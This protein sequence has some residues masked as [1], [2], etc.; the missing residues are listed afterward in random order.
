MQDKATNQDLL[1]LLSN[2]IN[3]L[4]RLPVT[5]DD[6]EVVPD[7]VAEVEKLLGSHRDELD[8]LWQTVHQE[9]WWLY[10]AL[11][12][13]RVEQERW[14][15]FFGFEVERLRVGARGIPHDQ[16]E[17]AKVLFKKLKAGLDEYAVLYE[18]SQ[19]SV[20]EKRKLQSEVKGQEDLLID[21]VSQLGG[22]LQAALEREE[23]GDWTDF[24][25]F[26]AG[27]ELV[28]ERGADEANRLVVEEE[29]DEI[30]DV[31]EVE[32][33]EPT[34]K[35]GGALTLEQAAF[36][37]LMMDLAELGMGEE[38]AEGDGEGGGE[39]MKVIDEMLGG[40]VGDEVDEGAEMEVL[41]EGADEIE[42]WADGEIDV[43]AELIAD[44]SEVEADVEDEDAVEVET[45]LGEMAEAELE[46]D[47]SDE[48]WLL[49]ADTIGEE[50]EE[51]VSVVDDEF[52]VGVLAEVEEWI[53]DGGVIDEEEA[54]GE[55]GDV[56][57]GDVVVGATDDAVVDEDELIGEE[58]VLSVD[59]G[60]G[61]IDELDILAGM[62]D[63]WLNADSELADLADSMAGDFDVY[64][65][66]EADLGEVGEEEMGEIPAALEAA[67]DIEPV[68]DSWDVELGGEGETVVSGL[69][70]VSGGEEEAEEA[71][72]EGAEEAEGEDINEAQANWARMM[73]LAGDVAGGYWVTRSLQ[74]QNGAFASLLWP[75][76]LLAAIQ[77]S[78]WLINGAKGSLP[79]DLSNIVFSHQVDEGSQEHLLAIAAGLT[80]A[81]V[82]PSTGCAAWLRPDLRLP[83]A[84]NKILEAV[85]IFSR[86]NRPLRKE[87][88]QEIWGEDTHNEML[89]ACVAKAK[90]WVAEE[91]LRR[92]KL[93]RATAVWLSWTKPNGL[94]RRMMDLVAGG[95]EADIPKLQ[96]YVDQWRAKSTID[97]LNQTDVEMCG[98]TPARPIDG[99]V[100]DRLLLHAEETV[101]LAEEW[102]ALWTTPS[103]ETNWLLT[104]TETLITT[105]QSYRV[106]AI[107]EMALLETH[108]SET[109]PPVLV[110]L[111]RWA[112]EDV[113]FHLDIISERI[114]AVERRLV[115][116]PKGVEISLNSGLMYRL[117][118][119]PEVGLPDSMQDDPHELEK[120]AGLL[121][122][123]SQRQDSLEDVFD[124]H[125]KQADYRYM[126]IIL[127]QE[128]NG[129]KL[130][131]LERRLEEAVTH[132]TDYLGHLLQ[133]TSAAVEQAMIDG[134]IDEAVR[135]DLAAQLELFRDEPVENYR[136]A[137]AVLK[138]IQRKLEG[139][140]SGHLDKQKARWEE[141]LE[142][143]HQQ[144]FHED[145]TAE[146]YN[147][148]V[149]YMQNLLEKQDI[150]VVDE[151]LARIKEILD[152]GQLPTADEF[153]VTSSK[154]V[155]LDFT[156]KL[157]E[158][159][160]PDSEV[161][162]FNI[163][164]LMSAL[165]RD[166]P[167]A[168]LETGLLDRP[169]LIEVETAVYK[170]YQLKRDK[171][172][173]N[174]KQVGQLVGSLLRDYL[175]F[176]FTGEPAKAVNWHSNGKY[177]AYLNVNMTAA[178]LSPIPQFGSQHSGVFDVIIL[179]ERPGADVIGSRLYNL[180]L[181]SNH[182][183]ILYVGRLLVKHRVD[184]MH[185]ARQNSVSLAVLDELLL[186]YLA[187]HNGAR[188]PI[189]FQCALPLARVN[190][191]AETGPVPSEMF[192]GRLNEVSELQNPLGYSLVYGGRQLGKSALLQQVER[193]FHKPEADQFV[194]LEAINHIGDLRSSQSDPEIVWQRLKLRLVELGL[195]TATTSSKPK[196]IFDQIQMMMLQNPSR[197]ILVLLDEADN[198]LAADK[199]RNFELVGMLKSL[200]DSTERRFKVIFTG[201]HNVQRYEGVPNQPFAH[202]RGLQVSPLK[203]QD[204][205]QLIKD[206][207]E[208]LGFRFA[209]DTPIFGILAY[210]NSHPGL[211]QLLCHRLLEMLYERQPQT[212]GPHDV[213]REDV[214]AVYRQHEVQEQVR[215]R[216]EWTLALD[217]R[218]KG[219]AEIIVLEQ[220]QTQGSY[221]QAFS[222]PEL[223]KL[224]QDYLS[225]AFQNSDQH[226]FKGYLDEMVG[227]G[228]LV[229]TEGNSY[230]LRS[231]NLVR[232]MGTEEELIASLA[233]L[234][235]KPVPT[236][237]MVFSSH[238]APLDDGAKQYSPFT[239]QQAK[240]LNEHE[241]GVGLVLGSKALGLDGVKTAIHNHFI[242]AATAGVVQEL[243]LPD[244]TVRQL[245]IRLQHFR[246]KYAGDHE[247]LILVYE[248]PAEM[249]AEKMDMLVETAVQFCQQHSR[250]KNHWMRIV[251]VFDAMASFNWLQVPRSKRQQYEEQGVVTITL[252]QYDRLGIEQRLQQHGKMSS[253]AIV[254]QLQSLLGGWP[255]LLDKL[256]NS[257][258]KNVDDPI[259]TAEK[260]AQRLAVSWQTSFMDATGW[261]RTANVERALRTIAIYGTVPV[262]DLVPDV[263]RIDCSVEQCQT[264]VDYLAFMGLIHY[265]RN[266]VKPD[267]IVKKFIQD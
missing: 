6:W 84:F 43:I 74:T 138:H 41:T 156:N 224:S 144:G 109:I 152:M 70:E 163:G 234:A 8:T 7:F 201:L 95:A 15:Q 79:A 264:I 13:L 49:E 117:L 131:R 53:I 31:A 86:H 11:G 120:V 175:G 216:F 29:T 207:F 213:T 157:R 66:M 136:E 27:E 51:G 56:E 244:E 148:I 126:D 247:R 191:Y 211:I 73:L 77:A 4:S 92:T 169:R 237:A 23:K 35:V 185:F 255:C 21:L 112:L 83:E 17:L 189:F 58:L 57:V 250:T 65:E 107:E 16:V 229:R 181:R 153:M 183:I 36:D 104:Q 232:L 111:L 93:K 145:G 132:S 91:P 94:L 210:S 106:E 67:V 239:F 147:Q 231:P 235:A 129:V 203:Q 245:E 71:E 242:P 159:G 42:M 209:D 50:V 150:V 46:A 97:H 115:T 208:A 173:S 161:S 80:T 85:L 248:V 262:S 160:H 200:M 167:P 193:E 24:D 266:E 14:V 205:R 60:E 5:A 135:S 121:W 192:K 105:V 176:I 227:L 10:Q 238:R 32:K 258:S 78:W 69:E 64:S 103:D 252:E 119:A 59:E 37:S 134:L 162:R 198:F 164:Q 206:P 34:V 165:K 127:A 225:N 61:E 263:L 63:E 130:K 142:R 199:A 166:R 186:L 170:W 254:R 48:E 12:V 88:V 20:A 140:R 98:Y 110:R 246:E 187:R 47:D 101:Q 223:R 81:L 125:I 9:R 141:V 18:Q 75:P 194:I 190:P 256:A 100:R 177:W 154:G 251:F 180:K 253:D 116:F 168:F 25:T 221:S 178:D 230:R 128:A 179:W 38:G 96:K 240:L 30:L 82:A 236:T 114:V 39:E 228:V 212:I 172:V 158:W 267:P 137:E 44:S 149:T 26:R 28:A 217:P 54:E 102:L 151:R 202:L 233:D 124:K 3:Q 184:L 45:A 214:E 2:V 261:Q 113:L 226:E 257:W 139:S 22:L 195:L 146:V 52:D 87:L 197:R 76:E 204:A 62:G 215:K 196:T 174:Q 89:A 155:Y 90:R 68:A 259:P 108:T 188:L 182:V 123:S 122:A 40:F 218:Y 19:K 143:L 265:D 99:S 219:L 1:S 220:L 260:V 222:I 118:W 133:E 243:R 171:A 249:G 33:I 241:Y 55:A 72:A